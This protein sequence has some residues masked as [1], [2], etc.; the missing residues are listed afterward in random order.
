[1]L[2]MDRLRS[3]DHNNAT[4]YIRSLHAGW[5]SQENVWGGV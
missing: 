5:C 3:R 4:W 1:M 2:V